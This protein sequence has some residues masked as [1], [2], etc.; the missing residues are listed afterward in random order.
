MSELNDVGMTTAPPEANWYVVHTYSGYEKQVKLNIDNT[1]RNQSLEDEILEVCIPVK[2]IVKATK[3]TKNS[4]DTDSKKAKT[5]KDYVEKK[6]Y[7]SYVFVHMV[8]NEKT[9]YI[10]RNTRGV[11][12]FVGGTTKPVPL[13]PQEVERLLHDLSD[14]TVETVV[15]FNVGDRVVVTNESFEG[16]EGIVQS[17]NRDRVVV[18]GSDIF[19]GIPVDLHISDVK[20]I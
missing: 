3:K 2:K 12:G 14:D 8:M 4:K 16:K 9:W 5:S 11:T 6:L 18:A 7:P 17:I 13:G 20:K 10:V 1:V 19:N 15:N